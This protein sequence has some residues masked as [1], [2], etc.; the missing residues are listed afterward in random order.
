MNFFKKRGVAI[1]ITVLLIAAALVIGFAGKPKAEYKPESAASAA[2][3]A[4]EHSGEYEQFIYDGAEL[5]PASAES[6]LAAGAAALDYQYSSLMGVAIIDGLDGQDIADAAYDYG[7]ELG[8]G[9]SDFALLIDVD[10]QDWYLAYG[11]QM[12]SYVDHELEILFRS[13]LGAE[14]YSGSADKQLLNLYDGLADWYEDN[15][16]VSGKYQEQGASGTGIAEAIFT[17]LILILLVAAVVALV[18]ALSRP[19]YYGASGGGSGFWRGMFWGSTLGRHHHHGP[20][21]PPPPHNTQHRDPPSGGFGGS[22][23]RSSFGS[24]PGGFGGSSRGSSFGGRSRGG[25]SRGGG[26]GGRR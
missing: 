19:R 9:E 11:D 24:R 26:F 22:T 25:G 20:P 14:L 23:N 21:P 5:L 18:R 4:K 17:I 16:P 1:S 3:W 10:T 2:A 6:Q 12:E 15:I 8:C 13:Y 7:Y